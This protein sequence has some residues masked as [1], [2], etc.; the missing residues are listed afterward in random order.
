MSIVTEF[1]S[2]YIALCLLLGAVLAVALYFRDRTNR[3]FPKWLR[4]ILSFFRFGAISLLAFFLLKPLIK[5]TDRVVEKPLVVFAMDNSESMLIGDKTSSVKNDFL[6]KFNNFSSKLGENYEVATYNFGES[7]TPNMDSLKFDD[8]I[9]DFSNL[10][11]ELYTKYSNRNLGAVIIASDG[12]YNKGMNPLYSFKKLDVPIYTIALGD[13]TIKRDVLIKEVIHNRLA[14]LGNKFP[15]KITIEGRQSQGERVQVKVSKKGSILF[16]KTVDINTNFQ[17]NS[18]DIILDAKAVG[19]QRYTVT[20]SQI[21]NEVTYAN[22]RKDIF[23]DVLDNRQKILI[24]SNSPHPDIAALKGSIESNE[25]YEVTSKLSKDFKGKI[26]DFSLVVFHQIPNVEG[27]SLGLVTEALDNNIPSLFVAG[28]QMDFTKFNSLNLGFS[29]NQT[30]GNYNETNAHFNTGFTSFTLS[31]ES[32]RMVRRYPPL[33]MPFGQFDFS[34]GVSSVVFQ[35]VGTIETEKPLMAFNK[36]NDD[37]IGLIAAEGIWRWKNFC[38]LENNSHDAFNEL[39]LKQVQF[40]AA[41]EDKSQFRV[42]SG[43]NFLENEPLIFNG[44]VYNESY[45]LIN[46]PDVSMQISDEEGN[47]FNFEFSKYND[48]YRLEA[49]SLPVGNYYYVA[50]TRQGGKNLKE[51]GEFS[52]SAIQLEQLNTQADHHLL[53]KFAEENGGEMLMPSELD[54]LTLLIANNNRVHA[55]SYESKKLSDLINI[56]WILFIILGLLS[57]EWLLRK[58][59]GSY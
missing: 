9:T 57:L 33:S 15:I 54:Q 25:N 55:T 58:R 14:Y 46:D 36:I 23:I 38:Y 43:S 59:F 20:V 49:G 18:F 13:T 30:N 45:E 34:S 40:L 11:E 56:P 21:E 52:V 31:D 48:R 17:N 1:P 42:S 8:K 6:P 2:W 12:L 27:K 10:L 28:I 53:Y 7:V 19:L 26:E 47:E 3:H 50:K 44:E 39:I 5:T 35:R 41:K 16:N 24:L 51:T 4:A 29:F 22:N 37:K 32:K